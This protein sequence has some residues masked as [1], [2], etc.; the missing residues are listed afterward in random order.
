MSRV[1]EGPFDVSNLPSRNFRPCIYGVGAWTDHIFFAYDLVAAERP[2]LLVELGSD[3]GESYFAFCQSV[4]ENRTGTRCFAVDTWK[5]DAQSGFYEDVTFQNVEDHNSAHYKDFSTL[6]RRPFDDAVNEFGNGKIDILH[7]DGLHSEAAVLHDL[8]YWLPKIAPGGIL[9]LHDVN[10]RDR[11]FGVWKVWDE[12]KARGRSFTFDDGPGLGLWE[13]PLRR[14]LNF[15]N[16]LLDG[17]NE[18]SVALIDYYCGKSREV[19][20]QIAEAWRSGTIRQ[21]PFASETIIQIF[22]SSDGAHREADSVNTRIGHDAWK[23]VSIVLPPGAGTSPLR[24]DFVSS[25]NVIDIARI[26]VAQS[27]EKCFVAA[28]PTDFDKID[29]RGDVECLRHSKFLRLKISGVDPQLYLPPIACHTP[30]KPVTID[31]RLRV[32]AKA[33]PAD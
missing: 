16:V 29:I 4:A 19:R 18:S 1:S 32:H 25:L 11:G 10:V 15:R 9:L 28:D 20:E 3:R 23:D 26:G 31:L 27:D 33:P 12:L 22:Y 30:D 7:L 24:I 17:N 2:A 21:S 5:G 6:L 8:N 14:N 13:K